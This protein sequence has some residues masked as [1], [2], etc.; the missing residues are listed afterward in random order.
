MKELMPLAFTVV[1]E[2]A[3]EIKLMYK[4][5]NDILDIIVAATSHYTLLAVA[6]NHNDLEC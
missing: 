2:E 3:K 5:S 4:I 1:G 6:S